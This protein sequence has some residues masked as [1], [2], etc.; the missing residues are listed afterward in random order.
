MS[1]IQKCLHRQQREE[2][3]K[4]KDSITEWNSQHGNA[5]K[6]KWAKKWKCI[7]GVPKFCKAKQMGK[8]IWRIRSCRSFNFL[9]AINKLAMVRCT[10]K[11]IK[12]IESQYALKSCAFHFSAPFALHQRCRRSFVWTRVLFRLRQNQQH[13]SILY[14]TKTV[15]YRTW[16]MKKKNQAKCLHQL[17]HKR[18]SSWLLWRCY[19]CMA[20][21]RRIL[22]LRVTLIVK[23]IHVQQ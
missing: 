2:K 17:I 15:Y 3:G 10:N 5:W 7:F 1:N 19:V 18:A 9:W 11:I 12:T 4:Q 8:I 22:W 16:S 20:F 6:S 14:R 21:V 13:K 23:M